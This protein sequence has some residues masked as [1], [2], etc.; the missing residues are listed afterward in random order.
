M[1]AYTIDN[2]Y[3]GFVDRDLGSLARGKR[4]DMVV[5]SGD[6]LKLPPVQIPQ[7]RVEYTIIGGE[8][9]YVRPRQVGR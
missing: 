6:I 7:V 2:A 3:G 4:A 1:R 5:L 8:I 9:V